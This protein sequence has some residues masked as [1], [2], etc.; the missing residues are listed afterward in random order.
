ML[1]WILVAVIALLLMFCFALLVGWAIRSGQSP[2]QLE[3]E[4]AG[5]AEFERWKAECATAEQNKAAASVSNE[6]IAMLL[7]QESR[8]A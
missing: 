3:R 4:R 5:Y 2:E 8:D 6:E 7:N 1:E